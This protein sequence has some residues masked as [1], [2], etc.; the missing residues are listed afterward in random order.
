MGRNSN[1]KIELK[2]ITQGFLLTPSEKGTRRKTK[3]YR[4]PSRSYHFT[5][6]TF[7]KVQ[8]SSARKAHQPPPGVFCFRFNWIQLEWQK[9]QL[10]G[11]WL[12]VILFIYLSI[13]L[14]I[15]LFIYLSI[16]L[17]IYLSIYLFI[18][19]S[20]YLFIYLSTCLFIYLSIYL[21]IYLSIYSA[22][23]LYICLCM[24]FFIYLS[25]YLFA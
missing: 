20:I 3:K 8:D 21:F 10:N 22:S 2:P 25:I 11:D 14:S 23:Y 16:Y 5:H 13:Y 1:S 19:L 4:L 6:F 9:N 24:C 7:T 17:L 12:V 15:Y 18:Y